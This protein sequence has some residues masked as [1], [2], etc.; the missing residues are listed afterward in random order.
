MYLVWKEE[1]CIN[2]VFTVRGLAGILY[3]L[4]MYDRNE[5]HVW[6]IPSDWSG[7]NETLYL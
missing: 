2:S 5:S 3:F 1:R 6:T 4:N 7:E